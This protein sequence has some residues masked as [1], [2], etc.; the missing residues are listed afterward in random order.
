MSGSV[1][2]HEPSARRQ[3]V[4]ETVAKKTDSQDENSRKKEGR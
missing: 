3:R 1:L 4:Q 2:K